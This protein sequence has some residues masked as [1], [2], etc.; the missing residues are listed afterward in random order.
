MKYLLLVCLF[1]MSMASTGLLNAADAQT[2]KPEQIDV[3]ALLSA[4]DTLTASVAAKIEALLPN[5]EH[6]L[7]THH[8]KSLRSIVQAEWATI[9]LDAAA[10]LQALQAFVKNTQFID[11][12][13]DGD[14]AQWKTYAEGRR[15]LIRGYMAR[16]DRVLSFYTIH[17]PANW[18]ASKAYQSVFYLHGYTPQPYMTWLL[19]YGFRGAEAPARSA[20]Y[21]NIGIWGRGN[22][23]YRYAG[24]IDLDN[25]VHD[26]QKTFVHDKNRVALSGHS[27]G[28]YGS[29]VYAIS[30]P[31]LWSAIGIYSGSDKYAPLGSGFARNVAH[32]PVHI[33][34]GAKDATVLPEMAERFRAA[35]RNYGNEAK[36]TIDPE[37]GHMVSRAAKAPNKAWL[38]SHERK[39]PN[40]IVFKAYSPR[41]NRAWGIEL[42]VDPAIDAHPSYT[43]LI[44]GNTVHL[45]THG[46]TGVRIHVGAETE[47]EKEARSKRWYQTINERMDLGL[48][49]DVVVYWNG[50]MVYTGPVKELELG[51]GLKDANGKLCEE[52]QRAAQEQDDEQAAE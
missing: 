24:E 20:D 7:F 42:R 36:L 14:A 17:L 18:D 30:R 32:L 9:N 50:S 8:L 40:P 44:E 38:L 12:G 48:V 43:C 11:D 3:P 16:H 39:R 21:Y 25:A 29:W 15:P 51:D 10:D 41:Y 47:A 23:G 35:L 33:W 22:S 5:A 6:P 26:F 1:F 49:G 46:T 27:M 2:K 37:A 28:S 4:G 31:D 52:R 19:Q 13:L 34:H 45:T